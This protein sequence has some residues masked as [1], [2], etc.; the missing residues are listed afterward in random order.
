MLLDLVK[1]SSLL[2]LL[3]THLSH[4]L[5]ESGVC[6]GQCLQGNYKV[7]LEVEMVMEGSDAV[8][9]TDG[10]VGVKWGATET[11]SDMGSGGA[12]VGDA[13][14]SGIVSIGSSPCSIGTKVDYVC[15]VCGGSG[16]ATMG[17]APRG[18]K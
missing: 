17:W 7:V 9:A 6:G 14:T 10:T 1:Y 5:E 8:G 16:G 4:L 13:E 12:E 15:S 3:G 18:A 2:V 11:V